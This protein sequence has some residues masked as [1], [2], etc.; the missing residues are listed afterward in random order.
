MAEFTPGPWEREH[1]K[2]ADGLYRTEVFSKQYGGIATCD[3]TPKHCG[4]GV[5]ET[6]RRA[7]A[8]LIAAAPEMHEAIKTAISY[9]D[10]FGDWQEGEELLYC[11]LKKALAKA[12]GREA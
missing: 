10:S 11:L 8:R 2:G 6:C 3:W 9:L 1:R 7:N 5:T 4:N 12:E